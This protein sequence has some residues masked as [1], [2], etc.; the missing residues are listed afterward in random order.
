MSTAPPA[1]VEAEP[2][3]SAAAPRLIAYVTGEPAP[4]LRCAPAARAWMDATPHSFA[5]RCLPLTVAN[6]HGWEILNAEPFEAWWDGRTEPGGVRVIAPGG[7]RH[8]MAIGP[9]GSGL[10]TFYLRVLFRTEPE[11]ALMVSGP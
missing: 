5:Y 8:S 7:G 3:E 1:R 4:Q 10:L 6:S 9:F 2:A 11:T